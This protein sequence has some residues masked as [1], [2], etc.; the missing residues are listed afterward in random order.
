MSL[1]SER[2]HPWLRF[3]LDLTHAPFQL[4]FL[5]GEAVSKC[6]HLAGVALG[7]AAAELMKVYLPNGPSAF[8][9]RT[10]Q[11]SSPFVI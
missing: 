10:E 8:L 1:K 3:S 5:G 11:H 4:W 7:P 2:S 9:P 6:E